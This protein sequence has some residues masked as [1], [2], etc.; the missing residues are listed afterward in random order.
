[1]SDYDDYE[2][3]WHDAKKDYAQERLAD[4]QFREK[5]ER[6]L[7]KRIGKPTRD[8]AEIAAAARKRGRVEKPIQAW[9]ANATAL[10][11]S[12]GRIVPP[13]RLEALP[14]PPRTPPGSAGTTSRSLSPKKGGLP[15]YYTALPSPI[16]M[17]IQEGSSTSSAEAGSNSASPTFFP[18]EFFDDLTFETRTP[19]EWLKGSRRAV[20]KWFESDGKWRW[21]PCCL[22]GHDAD[23]DKYIIEWDENHHRKAVSRLNIRFE[24]EDE[25]R[26][27]RRLEAA[28]RLRLFF[29][30]LM[31]RQMRIDMKDLPSASQRR[32][33]DLVGIT[34]TSQAPRMRELVEEVRVGYRK[35]NKQ[36]EYDARH[37]PAAEFEPFLLPLLDA[38]HPKRP[39]ARGTI[40]SGAADAKSFPT[41]MNAVATTLPYAHSRLLKAAHAMWST[42]LELRPQRFLRTDTA[43]LTVPEYAYSQEQ[44]YNAAFDA[45][46]RET[47]PIIV[48]IVMQSTNE[49]EKMPATERADP[50][51]YCKLVALANLFLKD[52]L[53]SVIRDTVSEYTQRFEHYTEAL[54]LLKKTAAQ[55]QQQQREQKEAAQKEAAQQAVQQNTQYHSQAQQREII[56]V[57]QWVIV[58]RHFAPLFQVSLVA[59][60]GKLVFKPPLSEA[61]ESAVG[62]IKK[63]LEVASSVPSIDVATVDYRHYS[64]YLIPMAADD[65]FI[66]SSIDRITKAVRQNITVLAVFQEG[67]REYENILKTNLEDYIETFNQKNKSLSGFKFEIEKMQKYQQTVMRKVEEHLSIGIFQ[68]DCTSVKAALNEM[69]QKMQ[70]ECLELLHSQTKSELSELSEMFEQMQEKLTRKPTSPA[71]LAEVTAF[72]D[73]VQQDLP[74]VIQRISNLSKRYQMLEDFLYDVGEEEFDQRWQIVGWPRR[75]RSSIFS[76]EKT[77]SVERLHMIRD[78]RTNQKA[79]EEHV[80]KLDT[81]ASEIDSFKDLDQAFAVGDKVR[82]I[83]GELME[84][85]EQA[86]TFTTNEKLFDFQPSDS[87][88]TVQLLIKRFEPQYKLWSTASNWAIQESGWLHAP[89]TNLNSQNVGQAVTAAARLVTMLI[90]SFRSTTMKDNALAAATSLKQKIENF[91]ALMPLITKLRHPGIR[92]RHWEVIAQEVGFKLPTGDLADQFTLGYVLD[93]QLDKHLDTINKITDVAINEYTLESALEKM[94]SEMRGFSFAFAPYRE[95]GTFIIHSTDELSDVLEDQWQRAMSWKTTLENVRAILGVWQQCQKNW[96]YLYPILTNVDI[97]AEL[98]TEARKF[99]A[100]DS[101]WR[102]IMQGVSQNAKVLNVCSQETLLKQL[103]DCTKVLEQVHAA[104]NEFLET[105]RSRFNRFYFLSNDELLDVLAHSKDPTAAQPHLSKCFEN[106]AALHFVAEAGEVRGISSAEGERVP[107]TDPVVTSARE[108]EGWLSDCEN[109]MRKTLQRLLSRAVTSHGK[110]ARDQWLSSWPAQIVLAASMIVFTQSVTRALMSPASELKAFRA[111]VV[112]DIA[113]L[114][115]RAVK[116]DISSALRTTVQALLTLMIHGRDSM[117]SLIRAAANNTVPGEDACGLLEWVRQMRY[118]WENDTCIVRVLTSDFHYAYEY[119]GNTS[120]LVLTP[121]TDRVYNTIATALSL[122][123]GGSMFGPAGTGKTETVR[124]LSKAI[125]KMCVVFNCSA[126]LDVNAV[127]KMLKG[128]ATSG[129]WCCFDEFNRIGVEVLSVVASQILGIQQAIAAQAKRWKFGAVELPLDSTCALYVTMNPASSGS[130]G[131]SY[132]GRSELPDNLKALFRPVAMTVADVAFIAETLLACEGYQEAT[133]LSRRLGRMLELCAEQL[134]GQPHYDWGMRAVRAILA[135]AGAAKRSFPASPEA[136]LLIGALRGSTEPKLVSADLPI[137]DAIIRDLFPD[138][139]KKEEELGED[140]KLL[141]SVLRETSFPALKYE[142]TP[143]FLSK[144]IQLYVMM[145]SRHGCMLVGGSGSGKTAC[146]Q[147]LAHA[148]T[149]MNELHP[150]KY[151][152]LK[153]HVLNPKS[154]SVDQLYG[155]MGSTYEWTDGILPKLVK[156]AIPP[157]QLGNEGGEEQAAAEKEKPT[158]HWI[159]FDGPIDPVWAESMNSVL[160]NTRVLC[161]SSGERIPVP[162]NLTMLLEVADLAAA[163]PAT[164]SRVGMVFLDPADLGAGPIVSRWIKYLPAELGAGSVDFLERALKSMLPDLMTSVSKECQPLFRRTPL[165]IAQHI[166]NIM[167]CF[168]QRLCKI[169]PV[170][171]ASAEAA[172]VEDDEPAQK[173]AGGKKRKVAQA[174]FNDGGEDIE[175]A[176]SLWALNAAALEEVGDGP[177][178]EL[179]VQSSFIFAVMHAIG[180]MVTDQTQP[181]FLETF[182]SLCDAYRVN[183]HAKLPKTNEHPA[184]EYFF[185]F[186]NGEWKWFGDT[187][188]V[189]EGRVSALQPID[190]APVLTADSACRSY[191]IEA[192]L[193]SGKHVYIVGEAGAGKTIELTQL[194]FRNLDGNR[195]SAILSPLSQFSTSDFLRE[196][197]EGSL[198]RKKASRALGA[199]SGKLVVAFLD[200]VQAPLKEDGTGAQPPLELVRQY[201]DYGGWYDATHDMEFRTV[202]GVVF[203]CSATTSPPSDEGD[204]AQSAL[205]DGDLDQ[206]LMRHFCVVAYRPVREESLAYVIDK[207]LQVHMFKFGEPALACHEKIAMATAEVVRRVQN[208]LRPTVAKAHYQFTTYDAFKIIRGIVMAPAGPTMSKPKDLMRLWFAEA[209]RVLGDRLTCDEDRTILRGILESAVEKHFGAPWIALGGYVGTGSPRFPLYHEPGKECVDYDALVETVR[210]QLIDYNAGLR[211]G[212]PQLDLFVFLEAAE[213]VARIQRAFRS[214]RGHIVMLGVSGSGRQSLARLAAQVAEVQL[215]EPSVATARHYGV[216]EW[217]DDAK[218]A[219]QTAGLQLR[220]VALLIRGD[221]LFSR[222]PFSAADV[223]DIMHDANMPTLFGKEDRQAINQAMRALESR[224]SLAHLP[225]DTVELMFAT[226]F[227]ANVRTNLHIV[228]S[229]S[230]YARTFRQRVR[231]YKP[232]VTSAASLDWYGPWPAN[233]LE[234]IAYSSLSGFNTN[235]IPI[236]SIV[237][238][239]VDMHGTIE[240]ITA[241]FSQQ[242]RRAAFVPPS[243]FL[244]FVRFFKKILDGRR[245]ELTERELRLRAGVEKL[246]TVNQQTARI[247]MELNE[248][249]PQLEATSKEVAALMEDLAVKSA[250]ASAT[251]DALAEEEKT[252]AAEAEAAMELQKSAEAQL[253]QALPMLEGASEA[254]KKISRGEINEIKALANPPPAMTTVIMALCILFGRKPKSS[255]PGKE[256]A[257]ED[258]W[259]EARALMDASFLSKMLTFDKDNITD[260]I[261]TKLRPILASTQM[262]PSAVERVN[263]SLKALASWIRAMERYNTVAKAVA[264]KRKKAEEANAKLRER[265]AQLEASRAMLAETEARVAKLVEASKEAE[266]RKAALEAK[267]AD[268]DARYLRADTLLQYLGGEREEWEHNI[269]GQQQRL[270]TLTGDCLLASATVTYLGALTAQFRSEAMEEWRTSLGRCVVPCSESDGYSLAV[271]LYGDEGAAQRLRDWRGSGLDDSQARESALIATASSMPPLLLDP[272]RQATRWLARAERSSG[273]RTLTDVASDP[274]AFPR[275]LEACAQFG[276]PLLVDG[277]ALLPDCSD[278]DPALAP[279][280]APRTGGA[281]TIGDHVVQVHERFRLWLAERHPNPTLGAEAFAKVSPVNFA[282]TREGL[283]EQLLARVVG[284]ERADLEQQKAALAEQA[285]EHARVR[286]ELEEKIL[287]LLYDAQEGDLLGDDRLV[288]ALSSSKKSSDAAAKGLAEAERVTA[289]IEEARAGYREVARH[290]ALTYSVVSDL[291]SLDPMYQWS[292]EWF[293]EV[294]ETVMNA[295]YSG[296]GAPLAA[297]PAAAQSQQPQAAQQQQQAG[298]STAANAAAAAASAAAPKQAVPTDAAVEARVKWLVQHLTTE[299]FAS[300]CRGLFQRHKLPFSF[301]LSVRASLIDGTI[302][303]SEWAYLVTGAPPATTSRTQRAANSASRGSRAASASAAEM[304]A[305]VAP[306]WMSRALWGTAIELSRMASFEDLPDSM[307]VHSQA[308]RDMI[309]PGGA[310]SPSEQRKR[311]SQGVFPG[312]WSEKLGTFRRLLLVRALR[313]EYLREAIEQYVADTMGRQFLDFPP[314]DIDGAYAQTTPQRPLLLIAA[315]GADPVSAVYDVAERREMPRSRVA[316]ISLGAAEVGAAAARAV[317][318]AIDRGDWVL[319]QNCHLAPAWL[320]ELDK[321]V[322]EIP[323]D[324]VHQRFRL[325]LTSRS[326]GEFPVGI[327]HACVKLTY[328]RP[329]GVRAGVLRGLARVA[330]TAA[331]ETSLRE[332]LPSARGGAPAAALLHRAVYGACLTHARLIERAKFGALGWTRSYEFNEADLGISMRVLDQLIAPIARAEPSADDAAESGGAG[333]AAATPKLAGS[334]GGAEPTI[335]VSESQAPPSPVVTNIGQ[336]GPAI[337]ASLLQAVQ[338]VRFIV[339]E[340]VYGGY[341]T[342]PW[343]RRMLDTMIDDTYSPTALLQAPATSRVKVSES[344]LYS[345]P[346]PAQ[347]ADYNET[348]KGLPLADE[349]DA[350]GLGETAS[351][352]S[353]QR[354]ARELMGSLAGQSSSALVL[355][356]GNDAAII[357]TIKDLC[358]RLPETFSEAEVRKLR[359][360]EDT[361]SLNAIIMREVVLM[362]RLLHT[363][364]STLQELRLALGGFV[365]FTWELESLNRDIALGAIPDIWRGASFQSIK[366][367]GAWFADLLKRAEYLKTWVHKGEPEGIQIGMFFR[368]QTVIVGVMQRFARRKQVA[369]DHVSFTVD[370]LGAQAPQLQLPQKLSRSTSRRSVHSLQGNAGAPARQ[371]SAGPDLTSSLKAPEGLAGAEQPQAQQPQQP[372]PQVAVTAPAAQAGAHSTTS[373]GGQESEGSVVLAGLFMQGG[374]WGQG[375]IEE[376]MAHETFTEFPQVRLKPRVDTGRRAVGEL[377]YRCPVYVTPERTGALTGT[378][379]SVNYVTTFTLQASKPE[380]H[381]IKRAT[382]ILLSLDA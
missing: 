372:M 18:L 295:P 37:P 138:L 106:V 331:T 278:L 219:V 156:A 268:A 220:P 347:L 209:A 65:P 32:V 283:E 251:R 223:S 74:N 354:E 87:L 335:V 31:A 259:P 103:E 314:L 296:P 261:I 92:Q 181:V 10:A 195:Y 332:V 190:Y 98:P 208:L 7:Q 266:A 286:R 287:C 9:E 105:K 26:F 316:N 23:S 192:L 110:L 288:E 11:E 257:P 289:G 136:F 53:R 213:H 121:L 91:R 191:I 159:V 147:A 333:A 175:S 146:Y 86:K 215:V 143:Q 58:R 3:S 116:P 357:E 214:P 369:L 178:R 273:L 153:V 353:A 258:Y 250:E 158:W 270:A 302:D 140:V 352:I 176:K 200:N 76:V 235:K 313:P 196:R 42:C 12:K 173:G 71:E 4:Y 114:T 202:S 189:R 374:R 99:Q 55:Q 70:K 336:A 24:E 201:L 39:P 128:A 260:E 360:P 262:Q 56:E 324:R 142:E 280:L 240:R 216:S 180:D 13:P 45:V 5:D 269:A 245:D 379:Q 44:C 337:P 131:K 64:D 162:H 117:A 124:D 199:P 62:A 49:E 139:E 355:G 168:V 100:V 238:A 317:A 163:S 206:R 224:E 51:R 292:L 207:I 40:D 69:A 19:Q 256:P 244:D 299:V 1:M 184:G 166:L 188:E 304:A 255:K 237:H 73:H 274:Q 322:R 60:D 17:H 376:A 204:A 177:Q 197:I 123:Y 133:V 277:G 150:N 312:S 253:A 377:V 351:A 378:G 243:R 38:L 318:L 326:F 364:R 307:S 152:Q 356:G 164:V 252:Q 183:E 171:A 330:A 249:L 328:E 46:K 134:S 130:G 327:L 325:V 370:V 2:Y 319:L 119:I 210:S 94:S 15:P 247:R 341:V 120:R 334:V 310:L 340:C 298:A 144:I 338:V 242:S 8:V 321:I 82:Q 366:N 151:R 363:V 234:V 358:S 297:P 6:R 148:L 34:N 345:I 381:W 311:W 25:E 118:Y 248:L 59:E 83:Q 112:D 165:A 246:E 229:L 221:T 68:V 154:V 375:Q 41:S 291:S 230:P 161:L 22:V 54:A 198:E 97:K 254:L 14:S 382:A 122:S 108:V 157:S 113:E 241:D 300:V 172:E 339:A 149:K 282:A 182:R 308:W 187:T 77:N 30:R 160:D 217:N 126:S 107:F 48:G 226:R 96:M 367:M 67:M 320:P 129:T 272:Q 301:M 265:L 125:A 212:Q 145:Q 232:I 373:A 63:M 101:T 88:N 276:A 21:A 179:A 365:P 167:D 284:H 205:I 50:A 89:F 28:L 186:S 193:S 75:I 85:L 359:P 305:A 271:L 350:F 222:A 135:L 218:R 294:L 66:T 27:T 233:A 203:A 127:G 194:L 362:N 303:P 93:L 137:F 228:L 170:S 72:V 132:G 102:R 309:L 78:M 81:L 306:P 361:L 279:A 348:G 239:M 231:T 343:D 267:K 185:D 368:P 315:P 47:E 115:S 342:D 323:P 111:R 29:E 349:P 95:T 290:A 109:A 57:P 275:T 141:M 79:L 52:I 169:R 90:K 293:F 36:F 371:G 236:D 264:P 20:S 346:P 344:G 16:R 380:P 227:L 285:A 211:P 61:L 104:L 80:F 35:T 174:A 225:A 263:V 43:I 33:K 329:A 155:F 281:M 84:A